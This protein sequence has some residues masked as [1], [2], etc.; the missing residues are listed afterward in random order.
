MKFIHVVG[1]RPNFMKLSSVIEE[2]NKEYKN[3]VIHTGQHYD[4]NMS[5]I[6]FN[7]LS[8]SPPDYLL[9]IG[10]GSQSEDTGKCLIAISILE[11]EKPNGVIVYGDVTATLAGA[12]AASKLHIPI[13]HVESGSRSFDRKMPEEINRIIVDNI[14]DILLCCDEESV[15]NLSNEGINKNVYMVGNTAIDTF[16]KIY[17]TIGESPYTNKFVLC[18]LHR[19]FNV[20]NIKTLKTIITKLGEIPYPII[21]PIHPRTLKT[22]KQ[23]FPIPTNIKLIDPLG[24]KDFITHLKYSEFVISDSGG[25]QSEC[26]AIGKR[27]I[28]IRP[29]TEHILSVKVGANILCENPTSITPNMWESTVP[30]Y[31]TPFVWDGD[32]AKR[33]KEI[34]KKYYKKTY[35]F[36][37][38]IPI[39]NKNI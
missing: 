36:N 9:S 27:I 7:D 19:P 31:S 30:H 8:L 20:D 4:I 12:L 25:V 13:I 24:Y 17:N 3:I 1:T 15:E 34:I 21:F 33:I 39:L 6:F 22:L 5:D 32:S 28:T 10:G 37:S 35:T 16:K 11:K 2:L 38:D 23:L 26:A 18:T 14:A 29:T